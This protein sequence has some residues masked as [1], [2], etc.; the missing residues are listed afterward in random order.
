M[1][2]YYRLDLGLREFYSVLLVTVSIIVALVAY[3]I[4]LHRKQCPIF[5]GSFHLLN[6]LKCCQNGTDRSY[7]FRSTNLKYFNEESILWLCCPY[8]FTVICIVRVIPANCPSSS[9]VF[10]ATYVF[11]LKMFSLYSKGGDLKYVKNSTQC[12]WEKNW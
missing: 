4:I 7:W 1:F 12:A 11:L 6:V 2:L 10:L 8:I 5:R 9:N 3:V